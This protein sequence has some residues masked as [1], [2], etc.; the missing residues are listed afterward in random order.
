MRCEY[1]NNEHDGSYGTGRFCNEKCARGFSTKNIKGYK[2]SKCIDCSTDILI[3]K[4]S[5]HI[6]RCNRCKI[7][8]NKEK[9]KKWYLSNKS[10]C[11][12]C[13]GII[14]KKY[15]SICEKCSYDYYNIYRI[16]CNF[17]FDISIYKNEFNL[18]LLYSNGVYKAKNR[19][20]N[21]NGVVKDHIFSVNDSYKI[22][23]N[24]LIVSHPANCELLIHVN[25][26]KKGKKSKITLKELLTKIKYFEKKYPSK[27]KDI[28]LKEIN[29]LE[30]D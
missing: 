13:G 21:F 2:K 10:K 22:S 30:A 14:E 12:Y 18:N 19:G 4:Q 1:C 29:E 28:I 23:L 24:P 11:K 5:P 8:N 9:Y 27:N 20:D 25:N 3:K 15:R 7:L 26:L 16:R 17:S 6:S